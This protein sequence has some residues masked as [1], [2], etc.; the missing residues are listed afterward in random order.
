MF[1]FKKYTLKDLEQVKAQIKTDNSKFKI[2]VIEDKVFPFLEELRRHDFNITIYNDIER[3]NLIADYDIVVSDIKG[4]GKLLGSKL[5]GAHLI[6]EIHKRYPNIY[7]IAYSASLFNPEYNKYFELCDET[8]RK[9]IDVNDWVKTL[10]LA[11][12]NCNDPIYQ[13]EKSRKILLKNGVD[14]GI[15][16]KLERVYVKSIVKGKK[17]LLIKELSTTKLG[18]P[19]SVKIIF[20]SVAIFAGTLISNIL[21]SD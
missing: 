21:K 17:G 12:K 5:Q 3:I 1:G 6:E 16:S 18:L 4:V 2:A 19:D 15:V 20:D 11:I 9:G 8:K 10:E 13:W 7:L 14:I